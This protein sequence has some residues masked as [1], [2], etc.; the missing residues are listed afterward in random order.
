[1]VEARSTLARGIAR[2]KSPA[3]VAERPGGSKR[4]T[5]AGRRPAEG[6]GRR[7]TGAQRGPLSGTGAGP[8][9]GGRGTV[10]GAGPPAFGGGS[11]P[12]GAGSSEPSVGSRCGRPGTR[13]ARRWQ[14]SGGRP[15]PWRTEVARLAKELRVER[16]A[17]VEAE[18]RAAR[19][20]HSDAEVTRVRGISC[21]GGPQGAATQHGSASA[22]ARGIAAIGSGRRPL[23]GPAAEGA[24]GSAWR[25]RRGSPRRSARRWKRNSAELKERVQRGGDQ[26]RPGGTRSGRATATPGSRQR[27]GSC[28]RTVAER[29]RAAG[30]S[31]VI[32][33]RS[34][35]TSTCEVRAV[36][37]DRLPG[38]AAG[39]G[40]AR[41]ELETRP[42]REAGAACAERGRREFTCRDA[43]S[44]GG[45]AGGGR[46]STPGPG[47]RRTPTFR[48]T[49][50]PTP[51]RSSPTT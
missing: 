5:G 11:G 22:A 1:M 40:P 2:S 43:T 4:G 29:E 47:E 48:R 12:G 30:G 19:G 6:A 21:R 7:Q 36:A 25:P 10:A 27:G 26:A 32:A 49:R 15:R 41:S 37:A 16:E 38:G 24:A 18:S 44:C 23:R 39:P 8:G 42:V 50:W 34:C 31:H 13:P 28:G 17:R 33:H 35:W 45:G 9:A 51:W 20:V 14:H 3:G 46:S